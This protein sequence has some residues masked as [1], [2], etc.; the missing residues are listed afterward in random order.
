MP[1]PTPAQIGAFDAGQVAYNTGQPSTTCPF[2]PTEDLDLLEL[3][4]LW[5]RVE[6]KLE[7]HAGD[8]YRLTNDGRATASGV[9]LGTHE[10]LGGV[11]HVNGGPALE[12]GE[13]LTFM[14]APSLAT[15]DRTITVKWTQ[16]DGT[17]GTWR[18][19]LPARPRA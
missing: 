6:W 14:A 10:S 15:S 7:H 16:P 1:E 8:T 4:V 11:F 5:I 19:P 13:A 18:Y 17:A 3:R 2:G 9:D 12:P